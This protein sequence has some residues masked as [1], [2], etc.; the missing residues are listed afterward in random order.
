VLVEATKGTTLALDS[1][2][3][4]PL[5]GTHL[6]T[7]GR[8]TLGTPGKPPVVV[9]TSEVLVRLDGRWRYLVDHAS[10]GV[11]APPPKPAAKR[12]PR[13]GERRER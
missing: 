1:L 8:W 11:P 4:L 13:R 2:T 5:D 6:A 10:I 3:V 12:A 7:V 9:R